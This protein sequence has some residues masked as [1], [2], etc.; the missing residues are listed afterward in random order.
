MSLLAPLKLKIMASRDFA[1][2]RWAQ[3]WT[4]FFRGAKCESSDAAKVNQFVPL[5]LW[6][7]HKR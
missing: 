7:C 3:A 4:L 6:I 2:M 1:L 5:G